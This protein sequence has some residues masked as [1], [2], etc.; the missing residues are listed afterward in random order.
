M[1]TFTPTPSRRPGQGA[2]A[3]AR[4]GLETQVGSAS[5][6]RLITLLFDGALA[7][8]AKARHQLE[9]RDIA[10]RGQSISKA[11]DIVQNGLMSSLN[12]EAGGE[13]ADNLHELYDYIIRQLLLGNL[14]ADDAALQRCATLLGQIADAWR[15]SVDTPASPAPAQAFAGA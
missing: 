5:P 11:V 1:N 4:V 13:L 3:Y 10:G 6:Q 2:R 15:S 14:Q 7:A 9:T 12:R 8:I